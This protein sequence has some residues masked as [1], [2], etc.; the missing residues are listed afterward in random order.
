MIRQAEWRFT[1]FYGDPARSAR[2]W[3]WELL[4][5]LRREFDNPWVCVGDFNEIFVLWNN[6]VVMI[7]RSG[8]LKGFV[9]WW[10]I[11]G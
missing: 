4:R 8:R 11:V 3:N 5:Y 2:K 9:K 7:A 10:T 6:M 1:G